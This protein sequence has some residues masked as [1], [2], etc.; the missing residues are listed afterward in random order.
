MTLATTPS[1]PTNIRRSPAPQTEEIAVFIG[2][3]NGNYL[4]LL[5]SIEEV[6]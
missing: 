3:S 6:A 2:V 1:R 5:A 4:L